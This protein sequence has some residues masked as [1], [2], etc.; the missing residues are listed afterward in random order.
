MRS[1]VDLLQQENKQLRKRLEA[2]E[3]DNRELKTS[4]YELSLRLNM[5]AERSGRAGRPFDVDGLTGSAV[6]PPSQSLDEDARRAAAEIEHAPKEPLIDDEDSQG[7]GR[8]FAFKADLKGHTGA[9]YTARFSPNGRLL[10]SASFDKT[11]R[12]GSIEELEQGEALVL[13]VCHS[14]S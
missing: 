5:M 14:V 11:V 12:C 7:D 10:A 9:V 2:A 8:Q 4:L 1:R 13:Q 3:R 6:A